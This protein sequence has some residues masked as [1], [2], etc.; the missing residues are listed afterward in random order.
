MTRAKLILIITVSILGIGVVGGGVWLFLRLRSGA[1]TV[2]PQ[3]GTNGAPVTASGTQPLAAVAPPA[4]PMTEEE[5]KQIV[6]YFPDESGRLGS[7]ASSTTL[8]DLRHPGALQT[9]AQGPAGV[10][11]PQEQTGTGGVAVGGQ[12][13]TGSSDPDG[14]G[15][16]NDQELQLGTDSKNADTDRDGLMD[17]D[18]VKIY[19]TDPLKADSDGD[20]YSDGVEVKGGYNPI[21]PGKLK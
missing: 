2:A 20:G 13:L 14:D 19:R 3:I 1:S 18:E 15:L 9:S 6:V 16:T 11:I 12:A 8:Y 7:N 4:P 17:G 5:M 10:V 21:G